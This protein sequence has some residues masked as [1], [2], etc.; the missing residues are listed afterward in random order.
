MEGAC[1]ARQLA[2]ILESATVLPATYPAGV[3]QIRPGTTGRPVF[4]LPGLKGTAFQFRTLAAKLRTRRPI[5]AIDL[6][7]LQVGPSV[8][9]SIEQTGQAVVRRMREVQPVGPYAIIGYSFGGTLAV[10][11]ARQLTANDQKVEL[12]TV[13]D[14]HAPGSLREP[15]GLRKV[16]IHFRIITQQKL[17]ESCRYVFSRIQRR[18]FGRSPNSLGKDLNPQLPKS[19]IE[20]RMA[21]VSEHC[22]RAFNTHRPKPFSGRIVLVS[23]TDLGDWMEVADPSGS[24]GWGSICKG[25]VDVIHMSCRHLDV[26]SEPHVTDIAGHIDNLLNAT[27]S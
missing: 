25:G 10:E 20:R 11:V 26:L 9:E 22:I 1:T 18:L 15:S 27:A 8:L 24:G 3:V 14:A 2:A 4:C 16:A 7:Y 19:E 13:L 5:L 23:A 21:E 6:H 12:V 17:H